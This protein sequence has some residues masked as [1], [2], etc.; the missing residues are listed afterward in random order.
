[1]RQC[2]GHASG[3]GQTPSEDK[4]D[5][6]GHDTNFAWSTQGN[7]DRSG[8]A[9][10]ASARHSRRTVWVSDEQPV[11]LVVEI[12]S[13]VRQCW[14]RAGSAMD[15][16]SIDGVDGGL[17]RVQGRDVEPP[18]GMESRVNKERSMDTPS[19]STSPDLSTWDRKPELS[20]RLS[21]KR[22][23]PLG[24]QG[25]MKGDRT[26]WTPAGRRTRKRDRPYLPSHRWGK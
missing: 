10:C 14:G 4:A 25:G 1:M 8:L 24:R 17:H 19:S 2:G 9:G 3:E 20:S 26:H 6:V 22:D 5:R 12:R 11:E 16:S 18:R 13:P 21:S 7:C 23:P 15:N